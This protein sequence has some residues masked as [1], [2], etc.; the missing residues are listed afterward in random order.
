M[1]TVVLFCWCHND[2]ASVLLYFT[3][4]SHLIPLPYGAGSSVHREG[5]DMP[6]PGVLWLW[7]L[8]YSVGP[9]P[10]LASIY[11]FVVSRA[12]MAGAAIQ[13]GDADSSRAPTWSRLWFAGVRECPPWC[14][15]VGATVTVHQFFC[16]LH[17]GL[18]LSIFSIFLQNQWGMGQ[19]LSEPVTTKETSN[20]QNHFVKVGSSCMQGWRVNM[21]DA[22]TNLLSLPGD[23]DTCYFGVFDGHGGTFLCPRPER[24]A[25]AVL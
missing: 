5:F 16:I 10:V 19:T 18:F 8:L 4:L 23:K 22:H 15:I 2:N 25:G 20:C 13:A 3:F 7:H 11:T 9:H 1:S 6:F 24:S 12:F 14:S 21:E 17:S